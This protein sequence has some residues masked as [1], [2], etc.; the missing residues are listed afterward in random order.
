M[1]GFHKVNEPFLNQ[2]DQQQQQQLQSNRWE[3]R[4]STN[5]FRK[6]DTESLKN[7]KRRSSKTLNAQRKL[8]I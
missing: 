6:G 8:S 4:H 7:I 2:D 1:Y 5:Q 3:F